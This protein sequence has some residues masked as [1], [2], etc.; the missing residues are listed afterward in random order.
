MKIVLAP[1]SFKGSLTASQVCV[2]IE[3]GIRRVVPDAEIVP[4]PVADGG[5]GT[6]D[7]LVNALNGEF[8][9]KG[10]TGPLGFPVEASYGWIDHNKTA[11]IEMAAASG[12]CLV[13]VSHRNPF[14]TTTYGTGELMVHAINQGARR[15]LLGIGGSATTDCGT[16]MAQALGVRFYSK[17]ELIQTPMNGFLMGQIDGIDVSTIH[18]DIREI[19]IEVACDVNNPLLG[20]HG[21]VAVYAEQKGAQSNDLPLLEKHLTYAISVIEESTKQYV[22]DIPGA[23]AA[24]GLGAGLM[25]F[26]S[27]ELKSGIDLVLDAIQFSA[28]IQNADWVITGEGRIDG[29]TGSGKALAGVMRG[30]KKQGI[31]G[32]LIAGTI[33]MEPNALLRLGFETWKSLGSSSVSVEYA[34]THANE[35]IAEAAEILIREIRANQ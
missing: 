23:G 4:L 20:N 6:V 25:A 17:G 28:Q 10:V 33:Q 21:A 16:G 2:A 27:A 5:E 34:M 13:P 7:A 30:V 29:Q 11:V 8:R 1:D 22:R 14:E 18:S 19:P 9:K 24:G 15:I 12:L 31:R 26:C 3:Q 32:A 35:L